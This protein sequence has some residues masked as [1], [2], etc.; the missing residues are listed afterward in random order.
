MGFIK[1]RQE[2]AASGRVSELAAWVADAIPKN[3][4]SGK[5]ASAASVSG[6]GQEIDRLQSV[7]CISESFEYN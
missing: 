4:R 5:P 2:R 3:H 7:R 6:A 1:G